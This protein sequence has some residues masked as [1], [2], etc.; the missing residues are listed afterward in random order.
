MISP[1]LIKKKLDSLTNRFLKCWVGVPKSGTNLIFQMKEGMGIPTISQ[2]YQE[3]HAFNLASIRIKGETNVNLC[4]DNAI[5]RESQYT[6]KISTTIKSQCIYEKALNLNCQDGILPSVSSDA[7]NRYKNKLLSDI[8]TSV[9][10]ISQLEYS[11]NQNQHLSTLLKQ[12][13]FLKFSR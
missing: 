9:K 1:I 2:L 5:E 7:S 12:G 3:C 8:K 11:E 10:S 4:L 13:E 6:R